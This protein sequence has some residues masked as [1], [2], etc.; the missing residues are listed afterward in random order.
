MEYTSPQEI[1][2]E[3]RELVPLYQGID[4]ADM[5]AGGMCWPKSNVDRSGT[6]CLY[7]AG[8]PQGFGRFSV[9][10]YQPPVEKS[11]EGYL[12]EAPADRT[13]YQFGSGARSSRSRRLKT[14]ME[15]FVKASEEKSSYSTNEADS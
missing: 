6:R 12:V 15:S 10:E 5:G 2:N 13:L 4:Y 11:E 8:F 14:M 3:I 1:M 9:V 7:E